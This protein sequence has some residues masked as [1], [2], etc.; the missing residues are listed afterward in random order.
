MLSRLLSWPTCEQTHKHKAGEK[1]C[2]TCLITVIHSFLLSFLPSL[3]AHNVLNILVYWKALHLAVISKN[4]WSQQLI[5][6]AKWQFIH[7]NRS[8]IIWRNTR[9]NYLHHYRVEH[10]FV[11]C[12]QSIC[13]QPQDELGPLVRPQSQQMRYSLPERPLLQVPRALPVRSVDA[14]LRLGSADPPCG[15]AEKRPGRVSG[16]GQAGQRRGRGSHR[17]LFACEEAGNLTSK[18]A[19]KIPSKETLWG[20]R[21]AG[22]RFPSSKKG[23]FVLQLN[24]SDE[25]MLGTTSFWMC[26]TNSSKK[27]RKERW[28]QRKRMLSC[29]RKWEKTSFH[30]FRNPQSG[31]RDAHTH[32]GER[33]A[34]I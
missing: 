25:V 14:L 20:F 29:G 11:S 2:I 27:K 13:L 17:Y 3:D 31:Y 15:A 5:A 4:I 9:K 30:L 26:E 12:C 6:C 32:P 34:A 28:H 16:L 33:K 22:H 10:V 21:G 1:R 24:E 7:F 8:C 18:A 19:T 23:L